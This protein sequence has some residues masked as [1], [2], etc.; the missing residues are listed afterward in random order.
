[1]VKAGCLFE[2]GWRGCCWLRATP[3]NSSSRMPPANQKAR[4]QERPCACR[5]GPASG[6]AG[7]AASISGRKQTSAF[8]SFVCRPVITLSIIRRHSTHSSTNEW[9]DSICF[10]GN[11]P[12]ATVARPAR[13]LDS[14]ETSDMPMSMVQIAPPTLQNVVTI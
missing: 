12:R 3:M 5:F 8:H 11:P 9:L 10:V 13:T 4:W 14:R 6:A 7:V 1:M 2:L